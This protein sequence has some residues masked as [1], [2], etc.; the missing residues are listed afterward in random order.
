MLVSSFAIGDQ[1]MTIKH[2][3]YTRVCGSRERIYSYFGFLPI[4]ADMG[5]SVP[6]WI[7]V[8]LPNYAAMQLNLCEGSNHD[9]KK[10]RGCWDCLCCLMK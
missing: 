1:A 10:L 3:F 7:D 6:R 9:N 2:E 4:K 5:G 8:D